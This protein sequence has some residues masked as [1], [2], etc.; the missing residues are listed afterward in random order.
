MLEWMEKYRE[1]P[2]TKTA[3][4]IDKPMILFL[5]LTITDLIS[6]VAVFAVLMSVSNSSLAIVVALLGGLGA[7]YLASEYRRKAPARF[8]QHW[9][10]SM[11]LQRVRAVP[12]LFRKRRYQAFGP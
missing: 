10:W 8:L 2:R 1:A 12:R 6:G 4:M 11:G 3:L 5:G 9:S 7:M